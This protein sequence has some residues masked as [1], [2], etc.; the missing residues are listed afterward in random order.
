MNV[1]RFGLTA[2]AL[3]TTGAFLYAQDPLARVKQEAAKVLPRIVEIRHQIHQNPELS[4]R[5]EKTAAL[6]AG[7]LKELGL[8]CR[9]ASRSTG[10]SRSSRVAAPGASSPFARTLTRCPSPRRPTSRSRR[11]C[12]RPISV[13]MSG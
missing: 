9:P 12:A 1:T 7:Y 4:N 5:E 3:M 13:R 10:S 8:R 2:A 6:V 11:R